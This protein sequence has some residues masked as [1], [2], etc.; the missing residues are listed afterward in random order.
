MSEPQ[1]VELAYA[2]DARSVS[3]TVDETLYARDAIY[4]AAYLFVDRCFVF[5]TRPADRQVTVRLKTREASPTPAVLEELAG[6]FGNELLNQVVRQQV[7]DST[8]KLREYYMAK[9][10]FSQ[11]PSTNI[12]A[13]LAELDKEELAEA[14]LEIPTPWKDKPEQKA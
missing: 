9:A 1:T 10:F 3:F 12:D 11:A 14:S 8:S 13:L 4:G 5:L 6:E 2:T 7:A